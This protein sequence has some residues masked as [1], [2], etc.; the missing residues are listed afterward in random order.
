MADAWDQP[1]IFA[2][3]VGDYYRMVAAEDAADAVDW[4]AP[5]RGPEAG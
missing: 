3:L 2:A 1:E 5:R 4:T